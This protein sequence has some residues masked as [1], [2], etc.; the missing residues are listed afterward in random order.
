MKF[1]AKVEKEEK[2]TLF[3][4]SF[5]LISVRQTYAEFIQE[6]MIPR[7]WFLVKHMLKLFVEW[8]IIIIIYLYFPIHNSESVSVIIT[9]LMVVDFNNPAIQVFAVKKGLPFIIAIFL[10]IESE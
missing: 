7:E 9:W 5:F 2:N 4:C 3:S 1:F 8:P 6:L 10:F